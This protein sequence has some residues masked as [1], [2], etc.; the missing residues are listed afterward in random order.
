MIQGYYRILLPKYQLMPLYCFIDLIIYT[1]W[2]SLSEVAST[3]ISTPIRRGEPLARLKTN[4]RKK[5]SKQY[6]IALFT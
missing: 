1:W 4:N 5:L 6:T 3:C 2:A